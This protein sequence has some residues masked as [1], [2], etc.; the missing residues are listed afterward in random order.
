MIKHS[1]KT[2]AAFFSLLRAGLWEQGVRLSDH[3]PVDFSALYELAEEQSVVGLVAAGLEH[4]EDRKV[5]KQEVLSFMRKVFSYEIRNHSMNDFIEDLVKKMNDAGVFSVLV[6]GQGIAQCYSR[7][8]WRAAGDIDFLLDDANYKKAK[9]L[10]K[11]LADSVHAEDRDAKHLSMDIASWVV[12][13]HGRLHNRVSNKSD[14]VIDEVQEDT[15]SN[16][17]VRVWNYQETTIYLPSSDN[18]V[19]LIFSHILQHF[20]RGGIGLRQICDWC[21]LLWTYRDNIDH[22]LLEERVR[23]MGLMTEWKAFA[24]YAVDY[25]GMPAE[26]M[27]MYDSESKCWIRK[28][29]RINSF[30]LEVGNFG[31]NRDSGIYEKYPYFIYKTIS[32]SRH[33]GDFFQNVAVFPL[34]SMRALGK[35]L[36]DGIVA[37]A[38]GK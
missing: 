15:L 13:L 9:A 20:F 11:P 2:I 35:M 7:P 25:L 17:G 31:H 26:A 16:G 12:E 22:S 21:R 1:K 34:D 30:I 38:K 36:S 33:I 19:I 18:D 4:V 32:F 24:A 37:I 27:P 28:A 23:Q 14:N 10:L 3:D 6:K 29:M 5:T 8:Q